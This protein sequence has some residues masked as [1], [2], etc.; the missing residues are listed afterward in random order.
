MNEEQ[1]KAES[2]PPLNIIIEGWIRQMGIHVRCPPSNHRTVVSWN[3]T[4]C[5]ESESTCLGWLRGQAVA[6]AQKNPSFEYQ[7]DL[8]NLLYIAKFACVKNYNME[9]PGSST[10]AGYLKRVTA[11]SYIV[12]EV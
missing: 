5:H 9:Y 10:I 12:S 11:N 4:V 1:E 7:C 2:V 6:D 8:C 3:S